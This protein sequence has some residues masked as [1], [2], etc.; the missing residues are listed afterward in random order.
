MSDAVQHG[1][2]RRKAWR[3]ERG[4]ACRSRRIQNALRV[5]LAVRELL[6][7]AFVDDA[8]PGRF[9]TD[10]QH[11]KTTQCQRH[12]THAREQR[13]PCRTRQSHAPHVANSLGS[14]HGC[15]LLALQS[16][17]GASSVW[18]ATSPEQAKLALRLRDPEGRPREARMR[19]APSDWAERVRLGSFG[20][21]RRTLDTSG[22]EL[23]LAVAERLRFI[24][25]VVGLQP[26]AA[27]VARGT[28]SLRTRQRQRTR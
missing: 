22:A 21:L 23:T 3:K 25:Y 17:L 24:R 26:T 2:D 8:V 11:A 6:G 19:V 14:L 4:R 15:F 20:D 13:V 9:G 18:S 16:R 27:R 7:R 5:A 10:Q 1:K 12:E 28:S